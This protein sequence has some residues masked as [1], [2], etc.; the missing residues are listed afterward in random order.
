MKLRKFEIVREGLLLT[1]WRGG[2]LCMPAKRMDPRP[3]ARNPIV[4]ADW[5]PDIGH[6][7]VA[8]RLRNGRVGMVVW[9]QALDANSDP[10]Y[11]ATMQVHR[12]R[13]SAVMLLR[14]HTEGMSVRQIAKRLGTSTSQ[15]Q[16][17][18]AGE[19]KASLDAI[20]RA[21]GLLGVEVEVRAA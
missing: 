14:K 13:A 17:M 5:D 12:A 6:N 9:D 3:T 20:I 10:E 16:R 21:L 2:A 15:V 1:P 4:G 18:L 11:V 7:G 19:P 8:Y